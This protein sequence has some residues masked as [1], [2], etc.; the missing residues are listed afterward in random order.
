MEKFGTTDIVLAAYLKIQGYKMIEILKNG[1]KGTFVFSG[2]PDEIIDS[3]D[4]GQTLIEPK[5]L[6][7]EIKALT[8]AARR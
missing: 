3:Y 1:T 4:L 2:I 6:N 7:Y 5:S 8:T